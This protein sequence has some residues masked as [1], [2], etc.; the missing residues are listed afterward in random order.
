MTL[1]RYCLF[2]VL[3][4]LGLVAAAESDGGLEKLLS[5]SPFAATGG[6]KPGAPENAPL[7]FRGMV[8]EGN[9]RIFSVYSPSTHHSSWLRE[10]ETEGLITVKHFNEATSTLSVEYDSKSLSLTI[11]HGPRIA[12]VNS[13]GSAGSVV[14]GEVGAVNAPG[15]RENTAELVEQE[16]I[17]QEIRRRRIILAQK[18]AQSLP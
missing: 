2:A 1:L 5:N 18:T 7:E 15:A 14:T 10:N 16:R 13:P 12:D 17:R 6:A 11:K 9:E 3:L 4:S 8:T